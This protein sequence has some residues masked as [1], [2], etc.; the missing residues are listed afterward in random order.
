METTR[1]R[2]LFMRYEAQDTLSEVGPF[3]RLVSGLE[4]STRS[5]PPARAAGG[6]QAALQADMRADLRRARRLAGVA[7][8]IAVTLAV[9]GVAGGWYM[10]RTQAA[11]SE[12]RAK[13]SVQLVSAQ[14]S[15]DRLAQV[16]E[17]RGI[18]LAAVRKDAS[19]STQTLTNLEA[20]NARLRKEI[21]TLRLQLTDAENRESQARAKWAYAEG[22]RDALY[23]QVESMIRRIES[24]LK[25]A[26][27]RANATVPDLPP[28]VFSPL[29]PASGSDPSGID[30]APDAE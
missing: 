20:E 14:A 12:E 24:L 9:G 22:E 16:A 28:D 26:E 7:W 29:V 27:R 2:M 10:Q 1:L 25:G 11:L 3:S 6:L 17:R 4:H 30:I 23:G 13:L 18:D 19:S 21:E 8:L 15:A 5:L